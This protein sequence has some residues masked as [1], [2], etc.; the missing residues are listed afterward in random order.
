MQ[1][2]TRVEADGQQ[3]AKDAEAERK[4]QAG[5]VAAEG[6]HTAAVLQDQLASMRKILERR[7]GDRTGV[8][9]DE[10]DELYQDYIQAKSREDF[11]ASQGQ[12]RT[13]RLGLRAP[14]L[15]G[16]VS[17]DQDQ[18]SAGS[19]APSMGSENF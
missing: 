15:D 5:E 12:Q 11:G 17:P 7:S 3:Q 19:A 9:Q 4:R 1:L 2:S 13:G 10:P 16:G 8:A 14:F 6:A 18:R